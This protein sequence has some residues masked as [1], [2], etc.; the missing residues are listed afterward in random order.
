MEKFAAQKMVKFSTLV[1]IIW[2]NYKYEGD[3]IEWPVRKDVENLV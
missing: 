1:K 3:G 2:V